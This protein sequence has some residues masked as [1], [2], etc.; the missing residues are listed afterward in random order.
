VTDPLTLLT[1]LAVEITALR[2]RL[3]ELEQEGAR[4]GA[5]P[6][7]ALDEAADY[8]R[9]SVRTLDRLIARERVRSMTL[10]RR[11]LLHRDDL[12]AVVERRRGRT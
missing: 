7:F 6:W 10:G 4:A 12:D 8:L 1:E 11:R 3:D 2:S 9:I 5:S